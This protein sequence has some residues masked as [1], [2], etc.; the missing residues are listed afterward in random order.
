MFT[1]FRISLTLAV[2]PAST[3]TWPSDRVPCTTKVPALV[4]VAVV[5]STVTPLPETEMDPVSR[6]IDVAPA[7]SRT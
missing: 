7:T 4:I 3:L 2:A 6:R 5:P 1:P